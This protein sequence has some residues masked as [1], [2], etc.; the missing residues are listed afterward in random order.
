MVG[1]VGFRPAHLDAWFAALAT[2]ASSPVDVVVVGDSLAAQDS[3]GG[4]RAWPWHLQRRLNGLRPSAGA[5][6]G[7]RAAFAG[8]AGVYVPDFDASAGTMATD[9]P[10]RRGLSQATGQKATVTAVMDGV[11][12]V[13]STD[14]AYGTLTVRDGVGGTV[15]GTINCAAPVKSG[16]V[17]TSG[18]LTA[19]SRTLEVESTG[20]TKW[21]GAFL[22]NGT[23]DKGMRVWH[24]GTSGA[25]TADLSSAAVTYDLVDTLNP[26]LVVIATGTNDIEDLA[27][28]ADR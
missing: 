14:P 10:G 17:W 23:R 21:A 4:S 2:R 9:V 15:L 7:W 1:S 25:T 5:T 16:N 19:A 27:R 24:S 12:I 3:V 6:E 18:A 26:A 28:I 13:Y 11:S 22:H 20:N 8:G